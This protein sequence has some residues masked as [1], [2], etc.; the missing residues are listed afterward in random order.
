MAANGSG[1]HS[2]VDSIS[3]VLC[4][5]DFW[6]KRSYHSYEDTEPRD[7]EMASSNNAWVGEPLFLMRH[8]QFR[9]N[10]KRLQLRSVSYSSNPSVSFTSGTQWGLLRLRLWEITSMQIEACP[11]DLRRWKSARYSHFLFPL[12]FLCR[13]EEEKLINELCEAS[14]KHKDEDPLPS[15]PSKRRNVIFD[16]DI[17]CSLHLFFFTL[18]LSFLSRRTELT[19]TTH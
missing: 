18:L 15:I 13:K 14:H 19:L 2:S 1:I 3:H 8:V 12:S 7:L 11:I 4:V 9:K 5:S 17:G 6:M 16:T 10:G